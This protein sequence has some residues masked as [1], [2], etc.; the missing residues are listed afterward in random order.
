MMPPVSTQETAR[1][2]SS[3][4]PESAA[5]KRNCWVKELAKP[6]P[7]SPAV[8]SQ[9]EPRT[10]APAASRHAAQA[11]A[12]PPMKPRR[13]PMR[14]MSSAAGMAPAAVPRFM[15]VMGSVARLLSSA[16]R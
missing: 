9:N 4:L 15:A 12:A 11:M 5:A 16:S 1:A 3:A 7:K 10:I 6:M 14:R 8:K 13:R 2:R